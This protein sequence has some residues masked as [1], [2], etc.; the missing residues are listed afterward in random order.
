MNN[1]FINSISRVGDGNAENFYFGMSNS[2]K[3]RITPPAHTLIKYRVY[4]KYFYDKKK[5]TEIQVVSRKANVRC[6]DCGWK[7][8]FD[9]TSA[10]PVCESERTYL[11]SNGSFLGSLFIYASAG[12]FFIGLLVL[13]YKTILNQ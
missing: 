13:T 1:I 4:L 8:N 5:F 7:Y 9:K 10:C 11:L 2:G 6:I 3:V 12:L